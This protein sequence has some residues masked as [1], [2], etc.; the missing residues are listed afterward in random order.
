[1]IV[2]RTYQTRGYTSKAGYARIREVLGVCQRLYNHL[3]AER[4]AIYRLTCKTMGKYAQMKWLTSVRSNS[5]ELSDI[6]SLVER[7]AIIRLDR[8]FRNFISRVD[9]YKT[10]A[11]KRKQEGKPPRKD[12]EMPGFPRFKPRQRYTCIELAEVSPS[13]VKGNRIKIKGLPLIRLCPSRPLPESKPLSMRLVMHGRKLTVDLVYQEN[14]MPLSEST[15]A[16]GID[17]GVNERMTLSTGETIARLE[18]DRRRERRLQRAISRKQK[19]S[20]SRRRVV[21]AFANVKHKN[22]VR[23]RNI[24][25]QIT[26]EIVRWYGFISVEDLNIRN[27]TRAGG[28]HK[29]GLNREILSQ[30]WGIIRQQLEYK[31][32]WA[33]RQ[34]VKVNPSYTSRIC[35]ECGFVNGKAQEYRTFNCSECGHIADRDVNAAL[36]ILK[37]GWEFAAGSITDGLPPVLPETYAE[38]HY[39]I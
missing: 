29:K 10:I 4:K 2:Y 16:V 6:S 34:L 36:N 12:G 27:M 32:E 20:N 3:L 31:A 33:G 23:N 17:M 37:R 22:A 11:A 24:C 5:Q 28:A 13:M 21:A 9:E 19:D 26:T 38:W 25:H 18:V 39:G 35:S 1:M 15:E 8:A 14:V 7:G 30:G